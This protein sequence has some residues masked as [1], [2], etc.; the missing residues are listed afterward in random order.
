MSDDYPTKPR[1]DQTV[2]DIAQQIKD[3][4]G[5]PRDGAWDVVEYLKR[6][7]IPTLFGTKALKVEVL[8]DTQMGED[9]GLTIFEPGRVKILVKKTVYNQAIV[10]EGRSRMTLAHELG[11]AVMHEGAPKARRTLGTITPKHLKAFASAEHQAKVFAAAL[12]IEES[13]AANCNTPEDLA[14]E[15]MVSMQAATIE[16]QRIKED[17][18]RA[19]T[20]LRIAQAAAEFRETVQPKRADH[21]KVCDELCT[22][23]GQQQLIRVGPKF[24]CLGCD[25]VSNQFQDGDRGAES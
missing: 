12:L 18:N 2:R 21:P 19:R 9:E 22:S 1:S 15:C 14:I 5:L 7:E 6:G 23:C 4:A 25:A 11:H 17:R 3:S 13:V 16:F 24:L 8:S 20:A 10:G